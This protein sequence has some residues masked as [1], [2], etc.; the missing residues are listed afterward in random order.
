VEADMQ[1]SASE[2]TACL[3]LR[4]SAVPKRVSEVRRAFGELPLPTPQLADAR[5]LATELVTNCIRH[6]GLR[7]DDLI[8]VRVQLSGRRLRVDVIQGDRGGRPQP[9]AGAI[10][11]A[12]GAESGW[13]LYLVERIS[14]RWGHGRGRYWFELE[15]GRQAKPRGT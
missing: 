5:L 9:V 12:P 1:R 4:V 8:H 10:R 6:A 7:P 2:G 11:P 13:G 14:T 15:L 3:D